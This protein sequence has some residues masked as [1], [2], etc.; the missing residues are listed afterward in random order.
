MKTLKS[1]ITRLLAVCPILTLLMCVVACGGDDTAET[2][3][4]TQQNTQEN[5]DDSG[6][7][8]TDGETDGEGDGETDGDVTEAPPQTLPIPTA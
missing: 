4:G 3:A 2:D 7:G 1:I 5:V 6:N 8:E